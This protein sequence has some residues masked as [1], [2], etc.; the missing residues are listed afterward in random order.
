MTDQNAVTDE[1]ASRDADFAP[2]DA[3][4][5]SYAN[6]FSDPFKIVIIRAIEWVT[7]KLPLLR[8]IRRFEKLGSP[9]GHGFFTQ[10]LNVM[11]IEVKTPPNQTAKIPTTGPLVV[12]ANHPHGLTDGLVMA[13]LIGQVRTDYKILTRSLLT[14]IPEIDPFMLPVPF[15]HEK[16]SH[17]KSIT[18]RNEAM[19]QLKSGGVIVLFPA[20]AV[21]T[22]QTLFGPV[23][24]KEW[25][26]FTAKMILKSGATVLPIYFPGRNTRL[27]QIADKISATLRQGLLLHEIA[28]SMNKPQSPIIG[29]P[30]IADELGDWKANP[31]G[32]MDWL[33]G[34]TLALGGRT[35]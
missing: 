34:H 19:D 24:E 7:G 2:Y 27:Y 23:V 10:T 1:A 3:R 31:R 16:D 17:R 6:T 18:M 8:R 25:N 20:G 29:D 32:F 14:G 11:N 22:S 4:R 5:L 26:P 15:P 9:H 30:I 13:E 28:R 35:D 12:V 21:A 33:R